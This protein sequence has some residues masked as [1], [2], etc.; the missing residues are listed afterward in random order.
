[1]KSAKSIIASTVI[2]GFLS[3]F[4]FGVQAMSGNNDG[5]TFTSVSIGSI[6]SIIAPVVIVEE[7]YSLEKDLKSRAPNSEIVSNALE[8]G[9]SLPFIIEH[10]AL[11]DKARIP[12][13][14]R[15]VL[16][17]VSLYK[18]SSADIILAA[19][20]K[21]APAYAKAISDA[22]LAEGVDFSV[23][24]AQGL[25]APG[26]DPSDFTPATAAGGTPPGQGG[27]PA[28]QQLSAPG[29]SNNGGSGGGGTGSPSA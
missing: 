5:L 2:L 17:R 1:M 28:G 10:T 4:S 3:A 29:F 9:L 14:V 16:R 25:L 24:A 26:V 27:T 15:A 6:G 22:A 7:E 20:F 23:I 18:V 13:M 21:A 12:N 8:A 11:I 19:A